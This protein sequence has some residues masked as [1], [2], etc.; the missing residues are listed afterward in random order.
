M[1][2]KP[3]AVAAAF[4]IAAMLAPM[5]QDVLKLKGIPGLSLDNTA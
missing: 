1:K 3:T 4:P 2:M 5:A